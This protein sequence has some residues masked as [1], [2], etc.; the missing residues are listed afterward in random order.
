MT[1]TAVKR[2]PA[3]FALMSIDIRGR[4]SADPEVLVRAGVLKKQFEAADRLHRALIRAKS[5]SKNAPKNKPE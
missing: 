4:L 5:T 3:K 1:D 2:K